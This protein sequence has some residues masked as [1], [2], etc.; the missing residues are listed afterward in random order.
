M[1]VIP[2]NLTYTNGGSVNAS[3]NDFRLK[4]GRV[5]D[6]IYNYWD[7]DGMPQYDDNKVDPKFVKVFSV[8]DYAGSHGTSEN[9]V[10]YSD[11]TLVAEKIKL[12]GS[13]EW[14]DASSPSKN[15]YASSALTKPEDKTKYSSF[16]DHSDTEWHKV[17]NSSDDTHYC[18]TDNG[19]ATWEGPFLITGRSI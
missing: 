2:G 11:G 13:V 19:G 6:Y 17:W 14:T 12:P 3:P 15:I 9:L 10:I 1:Q 7:N 4:M 16:S 8:G 18:H 5:D